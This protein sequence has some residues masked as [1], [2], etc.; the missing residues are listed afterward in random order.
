MNYDFFL[1]HQLNSDLT[2][3]NQRPYLTSSNDNVGNKWVE[4]SITAAAA[5]EMLVG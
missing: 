4:K 2:T 3:R 5:S 1:N